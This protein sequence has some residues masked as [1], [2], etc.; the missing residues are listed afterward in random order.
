MRQVEELFAYSLSIVV[1][2]LGLTLIFISLII[3]NSLVSS[4]LRGFGIALCPA[5]MIGFLFQYLH[6]KVFVQKIENLISSKLLI[7]Q[8]IGI[9]RIFR[10]RSGFNEIRLKLYREA[11]DRIYYLAVCPSYQAPDGTTLPGIVK[12]LLKKGIEFKFLICDPNRPFMTQWIGFFDPSVYPK[13]S[14]GGIDRCIQELNEV[15]KE[16]KGPGK[17]DIRIYT[18]SPGYYMQIIDDRLFVEPYLYGSGGGDALMIE[19]EKGEQFDRFSGHFERLWESKNS[20]SV[21]K[22][23]ETAH[24]SG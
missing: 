17:I 14:N 24:D 4:A 7:P 22:M 20:K 19:F 1:F 2:L 11:K 8:E 12:E 10:N 3:E 18:E 5:G 6:E 23:L 9:K 16:N 15:K 21:E 13:T